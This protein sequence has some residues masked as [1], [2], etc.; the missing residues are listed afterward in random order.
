MAGDEIFFL[1]LYLSALHIAVVREHTTF[2]NPNK[3]A[4]WGVNK[5]IQVTLILAFEIVIVQLL[6]FTQYILVFVL[7]Y[8]FKS[9]VLLPVPTSISI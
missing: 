4:I 3:S 1:F 7:F 8:H 9:S 2:L 5:K 6:V